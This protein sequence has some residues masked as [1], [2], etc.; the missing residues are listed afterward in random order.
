M[1]NNL[2]LIFLALFFIGVSCKKK[3]DTAGQKQNTPENTET[4]KKLPTADNSQNALDWDGTYQ[5]VLP[6]A[7]CIGIE[8]QITLN[9]DLT[10]TKTQKYLG[11]SDSTFSSK[12][13]FKWN[14]AGSKIYLD[15][16]EKQAYQVGENKL[17][18][19][20][21]EGKKISGDLEDL[22]ILNKLS[23]GLQWLETYWYLTAINGQAIDPAS[24]Q[25]EAHLIF[26]VNDSLVAGSGGCNRLSGSYTLKPNQG[27]GFSQMRSTMMA[28][29]NMS[30]E[31]E[32]NKSLQKVTQYKLQDNSLKFLNQ[33]NQAILKFNK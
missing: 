11:K 2:N 14:E 8:T 15:K 27:I 18:A 30:V 3:S 22:Y 13:Q 7:D 26:R 25:N 33:N 23:E 31:Q 10:Y 5:G 24:L 1:M 29:K 17:F 19:L 12:G 4:Q 28:C 20:D 9:N 6:C 21:L 32:L 16:N